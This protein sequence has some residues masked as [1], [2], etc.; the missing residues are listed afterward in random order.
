MK[1]SL[2]KSN[3]GIFILAYSRLTHLKKTIYALDNR[4]SKDDKIYIFCDNFSN[5]QNTKIVS[6]VKGVIKYLENLDKKRFIVTFRNER[7]GLRKNWHLAWSY[8]FNKFDKVVC[9]EDDIVI[10]KNFLPFMKYYL[11]LYK[12]NPR[13]MNISGFSTK[14]KI[15]KDYEYDCYL[16]KRSMSWGQGSWRRVWLKFE[17]QKQNHKNILKVK[18]NKKKL[19][20]AGGEDILR[21]MILDYWKIIESIQVWWIWN[22]IRNNGYCINPVGSLVKNIGFDGTGYHTKKGDF[23]PR[24][25]S[26]LPKKK[27]EKPFFSEKIN[28]QFLNK[29]KLK[30]INYHL[31]N[32]L[33]LALINHLFKI[34]NFIKFN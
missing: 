25:K 29:F 13:I 11:N 7:L 33:P 17:K 24:N 9:L 8:M 12:N 19:I 34:K 4:L 27:M 30:A 20:L 10:N 23:F 18:K 28:K 14:M 6:K 26:Y 32:H 1:V 16:T 31:F 3:I 15:P 2:T 5:D 22:I 21:A